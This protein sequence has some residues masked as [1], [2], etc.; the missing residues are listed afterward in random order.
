MTFKDKT[1]ETEWMEEREVVHQVR[2]LFVFLR[3]TVST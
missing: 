1:V 3:P 2:L